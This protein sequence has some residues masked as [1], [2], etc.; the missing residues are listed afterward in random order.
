MSRG[1]CLGSCGYSF[2]FVV[3]GSVFMLEACVFVFEAGVLCLR[4]VRRFL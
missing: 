2:G 1:R 4:C 3:A